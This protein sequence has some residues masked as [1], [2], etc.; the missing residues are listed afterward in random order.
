[1]EIDIENQRYP[2]QLKNIK[3][4]KMLWRLR[5]DLHSYF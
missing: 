4:I 3:N 5:H 2:E 1:M